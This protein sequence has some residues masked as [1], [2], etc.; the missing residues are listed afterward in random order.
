M[1]SSRWSRQHELNASL[2][3]QCFFFFSLCTCYGFRY[4]MVSG[5]GVLWD[6]CVQMCV[7]LAPFL[8][9]FVLFCYVVFYYSSDACLF[10]SKDRKG[11]DSEGR[12]GRR[13]K[14]NQYIFSIEEETNCS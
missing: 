5:L 12:T 9:C 11:A 6:S 10:S 13:R 2:E 4:V 3:I 14:T 7:C 8:V 1:P